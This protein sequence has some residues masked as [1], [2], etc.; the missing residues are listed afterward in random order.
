MIG[1]RQSKK[2]KLI[3]EKST[4]I[5]EAV[6]DGKEMDEM[7]QCLRL[8]VVERIKGLPSVILTETNA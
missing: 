2:I 8:E 5:K 7:H 1:K 4:E 3:I 6:V